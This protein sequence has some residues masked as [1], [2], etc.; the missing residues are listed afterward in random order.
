MALSAEPVWQLGAELGEGPVWLPDEAALR[1]VDIKRGLLH[2]YDPATCAGQTQD[3][4]GKPSF[5]VPEEGGGFLI[6]SENQVFRLEGA[7]LGEVAA[8][9]PQPASNR[10]NDA[11]VDCGGRLWFGT[12]DEHESSASGTVWCMDRGE[13]QRAGGKAVVTN[14]PAVSGDGR[15]LYFVNSSERIIWRF[16]IS[17]RPV[18]EHG[19]IFIE[20]G[21]DEGHPDGIIVDSEDCIWVALWDGWGVRRYAPDGTLLLHVPL[22]CARVTKV[23][24][25]GPDLTT[26]FVTTACIGLDAGALA[27]QPLAGS[28]FAFDAPAPGRILPGVRRC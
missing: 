27:R 24:L 14:G 5:I 12:M 7:T 9:I 2:R 17:N 18:L 16:D 4:G 15:F 8:T 19:E 23:A 10:T 6:G 25:G 3:V 28:L 22:P 1:F 26:A 21:K 13:L 11:T 20:F